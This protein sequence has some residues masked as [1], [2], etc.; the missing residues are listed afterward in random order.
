MDLFSD[1][2]YSPCN[3]SSY[4]TSVSIF[5]KVIASVDSKSVSATTDQI[6]ML[7]IG[8]GVNDVHYDAT[9]RE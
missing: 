6:S 9:T 8:T 1:A 7:A 2:E 3:G 4:M 5:V